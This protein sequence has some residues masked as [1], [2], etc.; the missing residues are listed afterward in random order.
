VSDNK[1]IKD[2]DNL[3]DQLCGDLEVAKPRCPYR[4]ISI[5][6]VFAVVYILAVISYLGLKVDIIEYLSDASF[7]FEM[8]L[9]IAILVSAALAS[10]WLSYRRR[11]LC[12]P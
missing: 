5:W 11:G 10:S 6:L 9:A 8:G 3:I 4:R 2:T 12:V 1:D 7:I